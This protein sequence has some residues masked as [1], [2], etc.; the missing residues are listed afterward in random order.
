MPRTH[1]KLEGWR[2]GHSASTS[3]LLSLMRKYIQTVVIV[4]RPDGFTYPAAFRELQDQHY[5]PF[6][7]P[8]L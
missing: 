7:S 8:L 6:L 4:Q 5:V 3:G 2:S 1:S